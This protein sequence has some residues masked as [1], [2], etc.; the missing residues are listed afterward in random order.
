MHIIYAVPSPTDCRSDELFDNII[1]TSFM[2]TYSYIKASF[3][4]LIASNTVITKWRNKKT[5]SRYNN[6]YIYTSVY[7]GCA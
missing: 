1:I 5:V 6:V 2:Y 4:F 3:L 7:D